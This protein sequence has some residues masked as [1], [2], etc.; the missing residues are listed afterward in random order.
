M[1][2]RCHISGMPPTSTTVCNLL[3]WATF[4]I[5]SLSRTKPSGESSCYKAELWLMP[6]LSTWVASMEAV[7]SA[8]FWQK[9]PRN[10]L[11]THSTLIMFPLLIE[12]LFDRVN[13]FLLVQH[14]TQSLCS[15]TRCHIFTTLEWRMKVILEVCYWLRKSVYKGELEIQEL[16]CGKL[17]FI[18]MSGSV[19]MSVYREES[20]KTF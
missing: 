6:W 2:R 9:K 18:R 11:N 1:P 3:P 7:S 15:F 8:V 17:I 14:K 19:C 12:A 13:C 5:R 16:S 10:S 20:H 4:S